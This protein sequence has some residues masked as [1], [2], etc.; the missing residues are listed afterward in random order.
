MGLR[1]RQNIPDSQ[2]DDAWRRA[3]INYYIESCLSSTLYLQNL[4]KAANGQLDSTE[5]S[6]ITNPYNSK[7]RRMQTWPAQ[8]KNYPIITPIIALLAGEK[9]KRPLVYEVIVKNAD[10]VTMAKVEEMK[11]QKQW[12]YQTYINELNKAGIDTGEDS[13]DLPPL[14]DIVGKFYENWSDARAIIGQDVLDYIMTE[15]EITRKFVKGFLDW[16]ITACVFTYK[17]VI[18]E[19]VVYRTVSPINAGFL[20]DESVEFIEDGDAAVLREFVTSSEFLDRFYD[21][22]QEENPSLIDYIDNVVGHGSADK[23]VLYT[24]FDGANF[25]TDNYY[26]GTSSVIG[27]FRNGL[28]YNNL[29]ELIYVNWKSITQI[30]EIEY[31]DVLGNYIREEVPYEYETDDPNV[32]VNV[33][34]VSQVWEGWRVDERYWLS[35]K[36]VVHQRGTMNNPSKCKL[37]INGRIKK[38]GT[39][40]GLSIV[41]LLMPFQ[42]LYNFAR[43]KL[44]MTVAK[45]K[46][47]ITVIPLGLLPKKEGWTTETS[48]YYADATGILFL[49]ETAPNAAIS[50][51]AV[52]AI[53]MGMSNYINFMITYLRSIKEEAEEVVGITRQRKGEV[54]ASE[55]LGNTQTAVYQSSLITE[56][57]FA[58]Y[59]EFQERELNGLLDLSKFAFIN[60]KKASFISTTQRKVMLE[61]KPEDNNFM[62]SEFGVFVSSSSKE[63]ERREGLKQIAFAYAQN[64]GKPSIAAK[65][66]QAE[67]S[68]AKLLNELEKV[69]EMESQMKQQEA[70]QQSQ[71]QMQMQQMQQEMEGRKLDM[72]KYKIDTDYR[73]TIDAALIGIEKE[74][75]LI[76]ANNDGEPDAIAIEANQIKREE[77]ERKHALEQR[78]LDMEQRRMDMDKEIAKFQKEADLKMKE[79]DLKAKLNNK[80]NKK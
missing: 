25:A 57:L 6:Y 12:I 75:G 7:D 79:M 66:I 4:Y 53:D 32:R 63:K 54:Q 21:I 17:D 5:Y 78:K 34:W 16:I 70:E 56:D 1:P 13:K 74:L 45:H 43:F 62:G 67:G 77:L 41:E 3:S 27:N 29:L 14:E 46:D 71:S 72:E 28:A 64:T 39:L 15:Q 26:G 42:H 24:D 55:G 60:G 69:E 73:K 10:S 2:K 52:K 44:N 36:P 11:L 61:I 23:R 31:Y 19:D 50:L 22:I 47:K 9:R 49:D 8:L 48:M 80:Y 37:L 76:D 58:M 20:A 30:K 38:V 65:M 33:Y 68:F 18:N 40:K 35:V 51:N 59:D